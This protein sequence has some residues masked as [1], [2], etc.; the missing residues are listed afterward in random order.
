MIGI[1][2]NINFAL[3][4]QGAGAGAADYAGFRT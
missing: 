1:A 4:F 2:E 3:P